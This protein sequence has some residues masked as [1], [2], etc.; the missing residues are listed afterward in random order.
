LGVDSHIEYI[1]LLLQLI[2]FDY[3][4]SLVRMKTRLQFSTNKKNLEILQNNG[5]ITHNTNNANPFARWR[6]LSDHIRTIK[7]RHLANV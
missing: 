5:E 7:C 2:R 4:C 6:Y 1:K 3:F